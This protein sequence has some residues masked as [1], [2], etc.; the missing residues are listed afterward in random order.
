MTARCCVLSRAKGQSDD[1]PD[2][3]ADAEGRRDRLRRVV[4]DHVLRFV[5]PF[6]SP[7]GELAI[8][9][10][11]LIRHVSILVP[12]PVAPARWA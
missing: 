9:F 10:A 5:V 12:K 4:S 7:V 2:H 6:T 8:L 11:G 3:D 1:D